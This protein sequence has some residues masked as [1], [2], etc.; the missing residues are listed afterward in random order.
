MSIRL[1]T[2]FLWYLSIIYRSIINTLV[3]IYI[4]IKIKLVVYMYF[5]LISLP[6][7]RV[8]RTSTSPKLRGS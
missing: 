4:D 8:G 1:C 2:I 7:E 3:P 6:T 5:V